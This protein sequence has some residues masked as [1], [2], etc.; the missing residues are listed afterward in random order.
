M[1]R[2]IH[3]CRVPFQHGSSTGVAFRSEAAYLAAALT[4]LEAS[5]T[6]AAIIN[7]QPIILILLWLRSNLEDLH[8]AANITTFTATAEFHL[9]GLGALRNQLAVILGK[10][11]RRAY[12]LLG[13]NVVGRHSFG[14]GGLFHGH[15]GR[16]PGRLLGW[17]ALVGRLEPAEHFGG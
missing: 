5:D 6:S 9:H 13:D 8:S 12:R 17:L 15:S 3:R 14:V 10:I 4:A 7:C 11:N 2:V 1:T 16:I